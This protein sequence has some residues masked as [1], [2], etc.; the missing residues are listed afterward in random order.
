MN[1]THG[2][3]HVGEATSPENKVKIKILHYDVLHIYTK[4]NVSKCI[5]KRK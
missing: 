4:L 3:A 1:V 2:V 5:F